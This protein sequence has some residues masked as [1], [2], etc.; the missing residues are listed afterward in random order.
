M[1]EHVQKH[2]S[3]VV[4]HEVFTLIEGAVLMLYAVHFI[5][6]RD[7]F[8]AMIII[9]LFFVFT[10]YNNKLVQIPEYRY[11]KES[12]NHSSKCKHCRNVGIVVIGITAQ[13]AW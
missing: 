10:N 6:V 4:N 7:Y 9:V 8:V 5:A 3:C 12:N 2:C 13:N 1:R 11:K